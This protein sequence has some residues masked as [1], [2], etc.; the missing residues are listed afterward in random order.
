MANKLNLEGFSVDEDNVCTA[1]G[2]F[3]GSLTGKVDGQV[4]IPTTTFDESGE[5]AAANGVAELDATDQPCEMTIGAGDAG[6]ILYV[7]AS[8]VNST[9][10]VSDSFIDGTSTIT[11]NSVGDSVTLG[12]V[13][14]NSWVILNNNGC[15][16]S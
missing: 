10:T 1:E 7:F 12:S 2:G 5:I 16:L 13:G 4:E 15:V 3:V 8:N 11:F 6:L 9:T 14:V